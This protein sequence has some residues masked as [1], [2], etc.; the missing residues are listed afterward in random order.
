M[1]TEATTFRPRNGA[2]AESYWRIRRWCELNGFAFS[3][4]LNSLMIPI[5]YYLENH[6]EVDA[7]RNMATVELNAG[8]VDILHVFGGK[9]YPL[10]TSQ[11]ALNKPTVTLEKIEKAIAY[12]MKENKERPTTHDLLLLN[13]NAHAQEKLK[14]RRALKAHGT[15]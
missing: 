11:L 2:A 15:R 5:A 4:V 10:A 8:F 12:W 13:T 14:I 1:F 3:D 6:C 7:K 9:C